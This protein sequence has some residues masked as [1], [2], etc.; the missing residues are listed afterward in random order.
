MEKASCLWF[1]DQGTRVYMIVRETKGETQSARQMLLEEQITK[2]HWFFMQTT[3]KSKS[4]GEWWDRQLNDPQPTHSHV[5]SAPPPLG[6]SRW[7]CWTSFGSLLVICLW[8]CW[9]QSCNQ[10]QEVAWYR[11]NWRPIFGLWLASHP[12]PHCVQTYEDNLKQHLLVDLHELLIPLINVGCLFA[13]IGIVI[14]C[15]DWIV[16]VMLAPLDNLSKNRFVDLWIQTKIV[17]MTVRVL[18]QRTGCRRCKCAYVWNWH[19]NTQRSITKILHHVLDE[20]RSVGDIFVCLWRVV[21]WEV[22]GR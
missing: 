12:F 10:H 13:G 6:W 8:S 3:R 20:D 15:G 16:S 5:W 2:T 21:S 11:D 17:S 7:W 4:Y 14:V 22:Q 1:E 9:R 19:W 18:W